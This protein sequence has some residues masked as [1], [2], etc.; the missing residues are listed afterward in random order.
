MVMVPKRH[1]IW[2]LAVVIVGLAGVVGWKVYDVYRV[3]RFLGEL[4][5]VHFSTSL[6]G[7]PGAEK[8]RAA[9]QR[10]R[11]LHL[12]LFAAYRERLKRDA[13]FS[14]AWMLI[15]NESPQYYEFAMAHVASVPWPEVRIWVVRRKDAALSDE[16]R[17]RLLD[18]VLASPTSEGKLS[19]ARWYGRQGRLT[20]AEDA[21][22]DALKN[23][24]FFDALDAA[25]ELLKSERY[26]AEAVRGL[27]DVVRDPRP[28]PPRAAMSLLR[29]YHVEEEL[30]PLVDACLKN[31]NNQR[32]RTALVK[33]LTLL[34]EQDVRTQH[35][36]PRDSDGT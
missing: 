13:R 34:V 7:S 33:R 27:I 11:E 18:L 1:G 17:Q 36:D 28:F 26:R 8:E 14:L 12:N 31:P 20:E 6:I 9:H 15:S 23:G 21:Y 32:L 16:Y 3:R 24:L 29:L 25:D 2:F 4:R 22:Y 30:Q 5:L 35:K 10:A 19:A